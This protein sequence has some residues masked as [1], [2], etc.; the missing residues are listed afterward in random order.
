M[1][2]VGFPVGLMHAILETAVDDRLVRRN[3]CR[4]EGAGKEDSPERAVI[5]VPEAFA[6]ANALPVRYRALALLATFAGL[7]W[8]ELLA[9]PR[10]SIDLEQCEIRIIETT[11]ELDRG[12][13]LPR[14]RSRA[15]AAGP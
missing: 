5:S 8:G 7:R 4:I 9:L 6:L 15:L 2:L 10:A 3:P 12:D 13:L 1:G 11:A 14:L